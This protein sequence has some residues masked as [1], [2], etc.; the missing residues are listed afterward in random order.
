LPTK[1][2]TDSEVSWPVAAIADTRPVGQLLERVTPTQLQVDAA[3][4]P[5]LRKWYEIFSLFS[6]EHVNTRVQVQCIELY[7]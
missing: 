4:Q 1:V 5:A 6:R 7:L 3:A 2:T